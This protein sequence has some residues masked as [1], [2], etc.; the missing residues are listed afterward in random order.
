MWHKCGKFMWQIYVANLCGKFMWHKCG[1]LMWQ[2]GKFMWQIYVANLC[3]YLYFKFFFNA[4]AN[5]KLLT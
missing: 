5:S 2:C 1:K 3:G 4:I